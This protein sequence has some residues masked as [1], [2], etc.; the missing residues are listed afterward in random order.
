MYDHVWILCNEERITRKRQNA[1]W[2][3]VL[4]IFNLRSV[5]NPSNSPF[6]IPQIERDHFANFRFP[7]FVVHHVT[8][9]CS[10]YTASP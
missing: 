6:L 7:L 5:S 8:F 10:F 1:V 2:S 3:L 9:L 4:I